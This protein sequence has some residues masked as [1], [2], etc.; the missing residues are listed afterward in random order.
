[1]KL[2][3]GVPEEFEFASRL[4]GHSWSSLNRF[5]PGLGMGQYSGLEY[6]MDLCKYQRDW[7]LRGIRLESY[8]SFILC[9]LHG[10]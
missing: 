2:E 10:I 3:T 6:G 1:M 8:N 7:R 4:L 9:I 5:V